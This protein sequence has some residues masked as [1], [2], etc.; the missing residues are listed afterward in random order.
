M[1]ENQASD[2][3]NV[4]TIRETERLA[5]VYRHYRDNPAVQESWSEENAGNR[6]ILHERRRRIQRLFHE[7][8]YGPLDNS[9]ILEVGCGSGNV[10][11]GLLEYGAA[12]T[13][14]YGVDLLP[15]RVQAARGKYPDIH[16][17]CANAE[18]LDFDDNCFDL[19]LVFTV[20]TSILD[21]VMAQNVAQEI[22]RVL[23]QTGAILWY[24]FRYNN[25]RNPHVHGMNLPSI[26][27]LFPEYTHQLQTITL[28]PPL[29]RRLGKLTPF[30][31]PL[32]A[33]ISPLRTHYLGL[34]QKPFPTTFQNN[35]H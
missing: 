6:A 30:L 31:Y 34:L 3:G 1:D 29:A 24:D 35:K 23:S 19:I 21:S 27:R 10:L 11:A 22:D 7:G 9:L 5:G 28:L 16:F 20:F 26:Q 12:A 14:L 25:P 18:R 13:N 15:E 32:L 2:A 33:A 4:T 17:S 8:N